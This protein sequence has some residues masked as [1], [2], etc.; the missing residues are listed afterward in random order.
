MIQAAMFFI[1]FPL[2]FLKTWRVSAEQHAALLELEKPVTMAE[3]E[4]W[5]WL[6]IVGVFGLLSWPFRLVWRAWTWWDGF[7]FVEFWCRCAGAGFDPNGCE[8]PDWELKEEAPFRVVA[9]EYVEIDGGNVV[10]YDGVV[11]NGKEAREKP[12]MNFSQAEREALQ[13][14]D[15][16]IRNLTLAANAKRLLAQGKSDYEIGLLVGCGQ[17]YAKKIRL[18][19]Q[20]A[21]NESNP[22]PIEARGEG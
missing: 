7:D 4:D 3:L 11:Y 14:N 12:Q 18:A 20:R 2:M 17:S 21:N 9:N 6:A 15:P 10:V 22:S 19:L 5:F 16:P 13:N 8:L 1:L